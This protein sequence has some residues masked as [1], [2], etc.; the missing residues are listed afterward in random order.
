MVT[1]SLSCLG[2]PFQCAS[3]NSR[4][5]EIAHQVAGPGGA[6]MCG[7]I[8]P[9]QSY[10]E[11]RHKETVQDELRRQVAVFVDQKADFLLGEVSMIYHVFS[12]TIY[13]AS[14]I[15]PGYFFYHHSTVIS[16]F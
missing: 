3:L 8:S 13:M 15:L 14:F 2:S 9:T 5:C 12:H 1:L 11:V 10:V 16:R 6:L 4:A 7:G